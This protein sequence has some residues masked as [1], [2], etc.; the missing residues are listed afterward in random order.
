[1]AGLVLCLLLAGR[2]GSRICGEGSCV[3]GRC[4]RRKWGLWVDVLSLLAFADNVDDFAE[5]AVAVLVLSRS[6]EDFGADVEFA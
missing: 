2:L 5:Q 3:S 6:V 4:F 1:M